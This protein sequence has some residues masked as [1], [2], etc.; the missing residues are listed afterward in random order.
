MIKDPL[1][2][3]VV[4]F[5]NKFFFYA[6]VN[7]IINDYYYHHH[8]C[9]SSSLLLLLNCFV[10]VFCLF[11]GLVLVRLF[12]PVLHD[13]YNKGRG[14]FYPVCGVMHI[15]ESLLLIG[16]TFK[17]DSGFPLSL[18]GWCCTISLTPYNRK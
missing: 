13:W 4:F 14:M 6:F 8:Y 12:Q 11:V 17:G 5:F 2:M 10:C 9:C 15:K 1:S 16:K 7:E 18:S 3:L